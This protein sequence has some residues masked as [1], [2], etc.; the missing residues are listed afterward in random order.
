MVDEGEIGLCRLDG[1]Q[2]FGE[3][4]MQPGQFPQDRRQWFCRI[5]TVNP[6][7]VI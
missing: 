1:G 6:L 2:C 3:A 7:P 4:R 5:G